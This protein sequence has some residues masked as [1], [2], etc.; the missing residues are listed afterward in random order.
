MTRIAIVD[1]EIEMQHLLSAY[2]QQFAA[3]TAAKFEVDIYD[4]G[5]QLLFDEA[6]RYDI[7]LLDIQMARTN[8]MEV[9]KEIRSR[10][11]SVIL[12]F[13]TNMANYAIHGYAVD[14]MDFVVKPVSYIA[15]SQSLKKATQRLKKRD[16][17]SL[18]LSHDGGFLKLNVADLLYIENYG[19]KL[20]LHTEMENY[21][22][23]GTLKN[24]EKDLKD[25]DFF[26]CNNCYLVN[27][28]HVDS[29]RQDMVHIKGISLRV[30][31]PKKKAFMEALAD[32]IGG[33]TK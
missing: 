28:A 23:Y 22:T 5:D 7:I 33:A 25:A 20:I 13:I 16:T 27:L 2:I 14:A 9:A 8:G 30:S 1:D 26:R 11:P 19:H 3:E 12:A 32:Y 31:R 21:T 4:D 10:D 24:M 18:Q 15:L 6:R 17:I 29:V